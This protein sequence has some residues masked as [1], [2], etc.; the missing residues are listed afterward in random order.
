MSILLLFNQYFDKYYVLVHI[1]LSFPIFGIWV[2]FV[3]FGKGATSGERMVLVYAC[4]GLIVMIF[5]III[6]TCVYIS[7]LY[8]FNYVYEGFGEDTEDYS[9]SKKETYYMS[10]FLFQGVALGLAIYFIFPC[11]KWAEI[12]DGEP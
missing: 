8:K 10:T 11:L 6:W 2:L 7:N 1:G 3:C 12:A 4:V 9:R 5:V